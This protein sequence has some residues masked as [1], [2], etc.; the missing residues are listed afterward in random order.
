MQAISRRL[1][2]LLEETQPKLLA[3]GEGRASE[4]P[5]PEK[6]SLKEILGHLV[7]SAA[8]NHQRIVRMQE[9]SD[10]GAL[11]Y[12]QQH[13]VS[14]QQYQQRPWGDLVELWYHFNRHLAHVIA[15]IDP[16]TLDHSC[17]MG[18]ATPATLRFVVEDYVR[19]VR[20]HTEQI[21]GDSDPRQRK[22]WVPRN[23]GKP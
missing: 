19:H 5:F 13:W 23:P 2:E 12:S 10:I 4:K 15:H 16:T 9:R 8:N 3:L 14:S 22:K 18:Y 21:L 7:D 17:D 11:T 20:H 6:W 1:E